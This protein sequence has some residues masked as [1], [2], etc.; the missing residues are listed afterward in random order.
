MST[1]LGLLAAAGLLAIA[2]GV[3]LRFRG[4][5]RRA[6]V[7]SGGMLVVLL[8]LFAL[9]Q[10][11]APTEDGG[12]GDDIVYPGIHDSAYF[13]RLGDLKSDRPLTVVGVT[14]AKDLVGRHAPWAKFETPIGTADRSHGVTLAVAVEDLRH[15]LGQLRS[16]GKVYFL[17]PRTDDP[18]RDKSALDALLREAPWLARRL[19]CL[20]P[21]AGK[22]RHWPP[23]PGLK[24]EVPATIDPNTPAYPAEVS[25]EVPALA[26]A[27]LHGGLYADA[28]RS[29]KF[30]EA[31]QQITTQTSPGVPTRLRRG[32][33]LYRG[34]L[35]SPGPGRTSTLSLRVTTPFGESIAALQLTTRCESPEVPVLIPAGKQDTHSDLAR[36]LKTLNIPVRPVRID[37]PDP[38]GATVRGNPENVL[39]GQVPKLRDIGMLFVDIELTKE[40]GENLVKLLEMA[41]KENGAAPTPVFV[42]T[43]GQPSPPPGWWPFLN[44]MGFQQAV[45][46]QVALVTDLSGS[47][48]RDDP[49][50][51][52]KRIEI[53]YD[54]A[55]HL[56]EPKDPVT[57]KKLAGIDQRNVN[58]VLLPVKNRFPYFGGAKGDPTGKGQDGVAC[59]LDE[60]CAGSPDHHHW[61]GGPQLVAIRRLVE[62]DKL[63]ISDV[64]MV[65]DCDD[66]TGNDFPGSKHDYLTQEQQDAA[67]WLKGQGVRFHI[68]AI[69][70]DLRTDVREV[71]KAPDGTPGVIL[72]FPDMKDVNDLLTRVERHA[73]ERMLPRLTVRTEP[74]GMKPIPKAKVEAV[75]RAASNPDLKLI[76][77]LH[78]YGDRA[79]DP[80]KADIL[81][82]GNHYSPAESALG[83]PLFMR[84]RYQTGSGNREAYWLMLDLRAE[85]AASDKAGAKQRNALADLVIAGVN[86]VTDT[87]NRPPV[88]WQIDPTGQLRAMPRDRRP[89]NLKEV[90]AKLLPAA[91][92][93]ASGAQL[94]TRQLTYVGFRFPDLR[95]DQ[96]R[97]VE[98][99]LVDHDPTIGEQQ[100]RLPLAGTPPLPLT[101]R[102]DRD[103]FGQD[104]AS[105]D[106]AAGTGQGQQ[107]VGGISAGVMAAFVIAAWSL[108]A[109]FAWRG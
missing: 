86:V 67:A 107:P 58:N 93:A 18:A 12:G 87:L 62:N 102:V 6:V 34:E 78:K 60:Y 39:R 16:G 26:D 72:N 100:V 101:D 94:D 108:W 11:V 14:A 23:L 54:I 57:G 88:V 109:L 105:Q 53:A 96:S 64:L 61:E 37:L 38:T 52:K 81:L 44:G 89:F 7:W 29:L 90:E 74:E 10:P 77:M 84:G 2:T 24:G 98:V 85:M 25:I 95:P 76:N 79:A 20:Y 56:K 42:G 47:M 1:H 22:L 32:T 50:L 27:K 5:G 15:R 45:G 103:L 36:L 31:S 17:V 51:H 63:P 21:G 41:A 69:G 92:K 97:E 55:R 70:G 71:M 4:K 3:A 80:R 68:V 65:W 82:W 8:L 43:D 75:E 9:I 19:V 66:I 91:G 48:K 59:G 99:R 83:S 30:D 13:E 49:Y 46:R 35:P 106:E 28:P 33:T 40:Q 73:F 104:F